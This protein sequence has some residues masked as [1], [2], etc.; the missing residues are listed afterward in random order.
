MRMRDI[1][2]NNDE[3]IEPPR[4]GRITLYAILACALGIAIYIRL[5]ERL[6]PGTIFYQLSSLNAL[7][8]AVWYMLCDLAHAC[9]DFVRYVLHMR[10]V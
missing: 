8:I 1:L 2:R 3:F 5:A 7:G 10:Q 4:T 6:H 9:A